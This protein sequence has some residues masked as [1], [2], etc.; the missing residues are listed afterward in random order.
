MPLNQPTPHDRR[1]D[2]NRA[3]GRICPSG[4]SRVHARQRPGE[5]HQSRNARHQPPG[6][7]PRPQP[8]PK[9][10][11]S[12]DLGDRSQ[13]KPQRCSHG[14]LIKRFRQRTRGESCSWAKAL[15]GAT[16]TRSEPS[17]AAGRG[18]RCSPNR[19]PA[20]EKDRRVAQRAGQP[21]QHAAAGHPQHVTSRDHFIEEADQHPRSAKP[22]REPT[23]KLHFARR[24]PASRLGMMSSRL[25]HGFR[26]LPVLSTPAD[27]E[28]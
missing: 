5:N 23:G 16:E 24:V 12:S 6:G 28:R 25:D 8:Y 7:A 22:K 2:V 11:A 20:M 15:C 10:K 1:C 3:I 13:E 19:T 14:T 4:V 17:G 18:F 26:P 27:E 9:G 21:A